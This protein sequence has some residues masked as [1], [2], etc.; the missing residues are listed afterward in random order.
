MTVTSSAKAQVTSVFLAILI[1]AAF[2]ASAWVALQWVLGLLREGGDVGGTT[3]AL[4]LALLGGVAYLYRASREK[5]QELEAR[6]DE[7][8]ETAFG[9]DPT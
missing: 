3:N 6:L 8:A 2:A 5:R 7:N 9:L 1:V 4:L